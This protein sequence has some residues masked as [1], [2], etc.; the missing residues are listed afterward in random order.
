MNLERCPNRHFFNPNEHTSCPYCG[1][2]G[3]DDVRTRPQ[4]VRPQPD[5]T[6]FVA[7]QTRPKGGSWNGDGAD[8]ITKPL[9]VDQ[10]GI[11]PVVGWLVCVEGPDRGRDFRIRTENNAIGRSLQMYI[12]IAGDDSIARERHAS[13]TFE[14]RHATF[15]LVPG[16]ARGLVYLNGDPVLSVQPLRSYDE[17]AL[18][19]TKL[20]F[21]PFCG[22]NFQWKK[23]DEGTK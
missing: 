9:I 18:G 13:I 7:G 20:R 6:D 17:I 19:R 14:P 1:V 21:V 2:D 4:G 23:L 22:E 15:Y 16:D 5:H 8:P 12:S 10:Q 11:D 3:L